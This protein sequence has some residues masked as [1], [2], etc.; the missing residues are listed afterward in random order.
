MEGIGLARNENE[1]N[2][3]ASTLRALRDPNCM[4]RCIAAEGALDSCGRE[5]HG[6]PIW[7]WDTDSARS[8]CFCLQPAKIARGRVKGRPCGAAAK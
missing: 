3:T 5:R 8:S 1:Q 6:Q 4:R 7:K 2:R